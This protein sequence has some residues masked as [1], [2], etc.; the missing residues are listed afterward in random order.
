M[1]EGY[2][3]R[4]VNRVQGHRTCQT[5][6]WYQK[7]LPEGVERRWPGDFYCT[8]PKDRDHGGPCVHWG[9][10]GWCHVHEWADDLLPLSEDH[11]WDYERERMERNRVKQMRMEF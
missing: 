9:G 1:S 4:R 6:R 11:L 2:D 8:H 3:Y 5:C 10:G 7:E